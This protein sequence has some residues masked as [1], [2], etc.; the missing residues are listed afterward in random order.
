MHM[1]EDFA[2]K[3]ETATPGTF[4]VVKGMNSWS[5]GGSRSEQRTHT[6]DEADP[7]VTLTTEE[8]TFAIGGVVRDITDPGLLRMLAL[9]AS[10]ETA[11]V[12]ALIDG[13]NG[14]QIPVKVR[15]RT[16]GASAE[17]GSPQTISFELVRD[18]ATT[19]VGTGPI[20]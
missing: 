5:T 4:I 1:G 6:F 15:S 20:I 17:P 7:I 13:S 2:F 10:Q 14:S 11:N 9:R 16:W 19:E 12:Q 3:V 8:D 18:G